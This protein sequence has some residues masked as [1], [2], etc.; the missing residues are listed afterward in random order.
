[1]LGRLKSLVST[2]TP[3]SE[4]SD[5]FSSLHSSF[6]SALPGPPPLPLPK[7]SHL[8]DL[9]AEVPTSCSSC[10]SCDDDEEGGE[11]QADHEFPELPRKFDVDL[12]SEM[13]G[14]VSESSFLLESIYLFSRP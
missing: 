4:N 3:S 1:M 6:K 12:T 8:A 2:P 9:K 5:P 14:S 13:L 11:A 10:D 7:A